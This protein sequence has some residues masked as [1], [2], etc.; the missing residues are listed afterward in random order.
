M[1]PSA[2]DKTLRERPVVGLVIRVVWY[3]VWYR[4]WCR[5]HWVSNDHKADWVSKDYRLGV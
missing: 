5:P 1:R 3:R 2:A 4:V